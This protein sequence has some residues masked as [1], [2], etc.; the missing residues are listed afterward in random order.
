MMGMDETAYF[1]SWFAFY[2]AM[3]LVTTLSM[4]LITTFG[5]VFPRSNFL[6]IW[7]MFLLY[8]FCMIAFAFLLTPLF[9]RAAV[10]ANV[11]VVV[12]LV[13]S[14]LFVPL[15]LLDPPASALWA[16]SL[17]APVALALS[18][19]EAV[20]WGF[21]GPGLQFSNLW[22]PLVHPGFSAGA[23]MLMLLL[24]VGLYYALAWYLDAVVPGEYGPKRHPLFFLPAFAPAK[25]TTTKHGGGEAHPVAAPEGSPDFEPLPPDARATVSVRDLRKTYPGSPRPALDGASL[26]ACE[27]EVLG[28]LGHNAAGKTTLL[29]IL[30]GLFRA[31]GGEAEVLG[32]DCAARMRE[33]R[34]RMGVCM[35]GN[36]LFGDLT[37]REHLELAA[38]IRHIP[39]GDEAAEV[40]RVLALLSLHD[41]EGKR[42]SVLSG[43]QKRKLS[44]GMALIGSPPVLVLDEPTAGMDAASRAALWDVL[45]AGREG[46]TVLLSSH[47][48][49]EVDASADRI[50]VLSHGKTRCGGTPMFLRQ[51]FGVGYTLAIEDAAG[52]DVRRMVAEKVPEAVEE[53]SGSE[54]AAEAYK[55]PFGA[56]HAFP[57]LF[58]ELDAAGARY[59]L[60]VTSL[61]DVFLGLEDY[62]HGPEVPEAANVRGDEET[63]GLRDPEEPRPAVLPT[64]SNQAATLLPFWFLQI[65]RAWVAPISVVAV[66]ILFQ[67]V[68]ILVLLLVPSP[69]TGTAAAPPALVLD[70]S[71]YPQPAPVP[72]LNSTSPAI[73]IDSFLSALPFRSAA[74]PSDWNM[75]AGANSTWAAV[76]VS[77]WNAATSSLAENVAFSAVALH[78][79]PAYVAMTASAAASS[80]TGGRLRVTFSVQPLPS[81]APQFEGGAFGG[82][83]TLG[84]AQLLVPSFA[85]YLLAR[86]RERGFRE[87]LRISGLAHLAYFAACLARD[88]ALCAPVAVVSLILI[89]AVPAVGF[90]GPVVLPLL[91]AELVWIP[92]A[93]VVMY[94]LSLVIKTAKG[95]LNITAFLGLLAIAPYLVVSLIAQ[96]L[97]YDT[98]I[99]I[100]YILAAVDPLYT[101]TGALFFLSWLPVRLRAV[102]SLADYFAIGNVFSGTLLLMVVQLALFAGLLVALQLPIRL[103][104]WGART[105]ASDV[106]SPESLELAELPDEDPD[107]VAER[108]RVACGGAGGEMLSLHGLGKTYV[109]REKPAEGSPSAGFRSQILLCSDVEVPRDAV[110]AIWFGVPRG[111]CFGLLGPNGAGKSTTLEMLTGAL[112]PSQG[113]ASVFGEDNMQGGRT[114]GPLRGLAYVPQFDAMSDELTPR[115]HLDL[116]C[117][118]RGFGPTG[119]REQ[120][121]LEKVGLSEFLDAKAGTLSGGTKRKLQFCIA[122]AARAPLLILDEPTAGMDP[123]SRRTFWA[124]L[125]RHVNA[126]AAAAVL[127][128]HNMREAE[129]LCGRIGIVAKGKLR[130]LGSPLRLKERFASGYRLEA[131]VL[132]PAEF[133]KFVADNFPDSD[134]LGDLSS[135]STPR[136]IVMQ[137]RSLPGSFASCFALLEAQKGDGVIGEYAL[138]RASLEQVFVAVVKKADLEDKQNEDGDAAR[139]PFSSDGAQAAGEATGG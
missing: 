87:I 110:R 71:L 104:R 128:T 101:F 123:S 57:A 132:K 116:V 45:R 114:G 67:I 43:G 47:D 70:T 131:L 10:A 26:Q 11:G 96:L 52:K 86:D 22:T 98:A 25:M 108:L 56:S 55:I 100:H 59:D 81:D 50:A 118:I 36:V 9:R 99:I 53:T 1:A 127:S 88:L 60:R 76:G 138:S 35:Q 44:V 23:A 21:A 137:V 37:T 93:L 106:E 69:G 51:R 79:L 13:L 74:V 65:K 91:L 41:A 42:S 135:S 66:A 7:A 19:A 133:S 63:R 3:G 5:G 18:V 111:Q 125:S 58:E 38:A 109:S 28:L 107:V 78:S 95:A 16:L 32:M 33:I 119:D 2:G 97:N 72:V 49:E 68:G 120:D 92:L 24:D 64:W 136:R 15:S 77:A 126:D 80:A 31:S 30:T 39:P 14:S 94:L 85:L 46:R 134:A 103:A 83:L 117:R 122:A 8:A 130:C 124:S 12:T 27:G 40:N 115:E 48:L 90:S 112:E 113:Y 29:S 75:T 121:L 105:R 139:M 20:A 84:F 6:L 4:A 17:V 62:Q 102:P 73:S 89:G 129:A 61:E 82:V 34:P 54:G